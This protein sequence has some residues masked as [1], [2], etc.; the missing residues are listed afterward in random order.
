MQV[1]SLSGIASA[2]NHEVTIQ[3]LGARFAAAAGRYIADGM[4]P[5]AGTQPRN[6]AYRASE[7]FAMP[8]MSSP[9]ASADLTERG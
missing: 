2:T 5:L 9:F 6:Q 8:S 3:H 1:E 4:V 7:P